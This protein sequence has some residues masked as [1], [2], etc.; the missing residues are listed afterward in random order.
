MK[1]TVIS[2]FIL[3]LSFACGDDDAPIDAAVQDAA[4]PVGTISLT[5]RLQSGG[6]DASCKD[7][8]ARFVNMELVRVGDAVGQADNF[9]CTAGEATSRQVAEGT[10]N[11]TFDL[12]DQQGA[13][14][15]DEPLRQTGIDVADDSDSPI[16]EVVFALN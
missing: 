14:L 7:V 10:Y 13:S 3:A 4:P 1:P 5:W 11:L 16:G 8:G 12:L 15:L 2:L 6:A 9:N